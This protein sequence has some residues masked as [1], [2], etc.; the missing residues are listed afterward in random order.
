MWFDLPQFKRDFISTSLYNI[1][2]IIVLVQVPFSTSKT[3]LD[4]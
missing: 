4:I 2:E 1:W 3:A